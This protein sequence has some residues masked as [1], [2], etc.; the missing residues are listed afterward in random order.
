MRAL[1]YSAILLV[2]FCLTI[3]LK[4]AELPASLDAAIADA[5][6]YSDFQPS[7][8]MRA[9]S[10]GESALVYRYNADTGTWTLLEGDISELDSETLTGITEL[11]NEISKPGELTYADA[12]DKLSVSAVLEQTDTAE[13]YAINIADEDGEMPRAMKDALEM[14]LHLDTDQGHISLILMRARAPFKPAMVAKVETLIVEQRFAKFPDMPVPLL[15][16]YYNKASGEA[17]FQK[18]DEEFTIEFF[19]YALSAE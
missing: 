9:S 10:P 2:G 3:P 7:F 13:I 18:F 8:S 1:F 11:Q 15:Q 12:R 19:D 4:A 14:T 17:M 16:S 5:E 6:A